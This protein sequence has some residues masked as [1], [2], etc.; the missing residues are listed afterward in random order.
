MLTLGEAARRCGCGKST[1]TK[2]IAGGRLRATRSGDGSWEIEETDL[3]AY[4]QALAARRA[5]TARVEATS[6]A[7]VELRVRAELAEQ[8]LADLKAMYEDMVRQRDDMAMQRTRWETV[9]LH[10]TT[11]PPSPLALTSPSTVLATGADIVAV[12]EPVHWT[13]RAWSWM[14][15]TA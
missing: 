8:R 12:K 6:D 10:M 13:K 15:K 1:I 7:T 3:D 4:S 9:A 2:A 11:L 5:K 14:Q